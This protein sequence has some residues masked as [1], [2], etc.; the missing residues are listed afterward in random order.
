MSLNITPVHPHFGGEIIDIDLRK[1]LEA[2]ELEAVCRAMDRYGVLVFRN[3]AMTDEEHVAASRQFGDLIETKTAGHPEGITV[4][5]NVDEH[6]Q[7]LTRD[8]PRYWQ[9]LGARLWHTDGTFRTTS[10]TYSLLA[11]H[12]L[13]PS[14]GQTEFAFMPAAYD[15][16]DA[17]TKALV[18]DMVV[19]HS[20]LYL[21]MRLGFGHFTAQQQRDHSPARHRLV[22][23]NT[24]TERR[25][26]YLSM[27]IGSIV[28]WTLPESRCFIDDL[29]AHA[30]Q[31][32]FCYTHDWRP[33]DLV[34]WDNRQTMHRGR[35]YANAQDVRILHRTTIKGSAPT[36]A[37]RPAGA[38]VPWQVSGVLSRTNS[39]PGI[40]SPREEMTDH[41]ARFCIAST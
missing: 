11:A 27:H 20:L 26:L 30:T 13:P 24:F 15:A 7:I 35:P 2:D 8:A 17:T 25:S 23:Q 29:L 37:Q 18:E 40:D 39:F 16:L 34:M 38:P 41:S 1:P 10:P 28:G 6:G 12:V 21:W 31:T 19:E 22:L 3:Q 5:S 4:I 33:G 36:A 32:E 14:R 9:N